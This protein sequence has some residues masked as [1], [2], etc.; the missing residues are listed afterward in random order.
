MTDTITRER[1]EELAADP[2]SPAPPVSSPAS[3]T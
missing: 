1:L 2:A 3:T